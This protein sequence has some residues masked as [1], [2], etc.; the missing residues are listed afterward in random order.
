M[1]LKNENMKDVEVNTE[2]LN[3]IERKR[4]SHDN[5]IKAMEVDNV[6]QDNEYGEGSWNE[7]NDNYNYS[8]EELNYMG[9]G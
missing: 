2:I 3:Y 7:W 6:E 5:Q 8:Q 1:E 9:K 4:A